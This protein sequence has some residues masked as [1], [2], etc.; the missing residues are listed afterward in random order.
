[1]R[2][3]ACEVFHYYLLYFKKNWY[4]GEKIRIK[5]RLSLN[6]TAI[7]LR[8]IHDSLFGFFYVLLTVHLSINLVINQLNEQIFVLYYYNACTCFQH[9][10]FI[11]RRSKLYYTATGI[12][13]LCRWPSG[14]H[15]ERGLNL[16][17]G[18]P[19]AECD[20][21]SCCIIQFSPSDDEHIVLETCRG[22]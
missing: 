8:N 2:K 15:F 12:I 21:T 16:C 7:S 5:Q 22:I 17:T 10:V 19:P 1:M 13:T 14:A 3:A 6:N 4:L 11:T 9:Y 20:D 18:P